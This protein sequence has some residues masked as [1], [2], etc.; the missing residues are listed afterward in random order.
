M[1]DEASSVI[2]ELPHNNHPKGGHILHEQQYNTGHGLQAILDEVRAEVRRQP[3]EPQIQQK[4]I[5]H[6]LLAVT[7]GRQCGVP[8]VSVQA[9]A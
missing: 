3:R 5:V 6:L 2:V 1:K 8:G 4:S 7:L 9:P